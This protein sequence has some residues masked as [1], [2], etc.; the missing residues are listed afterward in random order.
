MKIDLDYVKGEWE[1]DSQIDETE[2]GRESINIPK[3]HSKYWNMLVDA[4]HKQRDNNFVYKSFYKI[5][6]DYYLGNLTKEE[7]I[8]YKLDP[9]M[10]RKILRQDISIFLDA[11]DDLQKLTR[12]IEED[13]LIIDFIEG[14]MKSLASRN[15]EIKNYIEFQKFL[16]GIS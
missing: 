5:K 7:C 1:K 4:K 12:Q 16:N 11:D 6:W 13:K 10:S 8:K 15:F 3:L 14:I 9:F 2:A